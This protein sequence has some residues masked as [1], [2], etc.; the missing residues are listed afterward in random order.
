MFLH[1]RTQGIIIKKENRGESDRL[2]T[3][4]TRNF[5]KVEVLGKAIRKISSKLRSAVDV[6]YFSELEFIQAKN[7]KTLTDAILI[8]NF[9]NLKSALG[10]WETACRISKLFGDFVRGQEP[11]HR[12]WELLV[13]SLKKLN[14]R[15]KDQGDQSLI[16]YYFFW[17]FISFLGYFPELHNCALCRGKIMPE[18]IYFDSRLGGLICRNCFSKTKKGR[19]I[20]IETVKLLRIILKKNWEVLSRIKIGR[21]GFKSLESVSKDYYSCILTVFK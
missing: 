2:F 7:R 8:D 19:E 18:N 16:Y 5:G 12:I 3:V 4:Y 1:Y 21:E 6:F 11:D 13:F 9:K 17:N 20:K 10:S 15:K 14:N